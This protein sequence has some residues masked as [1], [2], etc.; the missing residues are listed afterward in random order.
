M[1]IQLDFTEST[2]DKLYKNILSS[3]DIKGFS[4]RLKN[5][6]CTRC[7]LYSGCKQKV[8]YRGNPN[9]DI[10]LIGEAPGLEE[11]RLGIPF[12][13]PAG[14]LTNK[15]F[16]SIGLDT[17]KDMYIS[18]VV[19][20][21]P[22]AKPGT[23]RQNN[24]PNKED[25]R[26][27]CK[28]YVMREI[29]LVDPKVIIACGLTAAKS[30]FNFMEKTMMKHVSGKFFNNYTIDELKNRELFIIYHPAALLRNQELKRTMWK[31][32]KILRT[33]LKELNLL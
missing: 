25:H 33:K 26:D 11:D 32:I 8:L 1:K 28:P 6:N 17:E 12:V 27:K 29:E 31:H 7:E 19:K 13:G 5:F 20:C 10:M 24:T 3:N 16:E 22:T 23:G 15:I 2:E 14:K 21:R 9:A 30:V 4:D 18:N